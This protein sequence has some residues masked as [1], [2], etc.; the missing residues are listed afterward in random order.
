MSYSISIIIPAYNVEAYIEKCLNSIISSDLFERIFEIIM[1]NDGSTDNTL[2][3]INSFVDNN[4]IKII[5]KINGGVST[6]RN[7]G[8]KIA[9]GD[10]IWFINLDDY[11]NKNI[12]AIG[13]HKALKAYDDIIYFN[14]DLVFEDGLNSSTRH[15]NILTKEDWNET[16]TFIG[17]DFLYKYTKGS[18]FCV[19]LF[20]KKRIYQKK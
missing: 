7:E 20:N 4:K 19:D 15:I 1:V 8:L 3:K 10:Y 5:N 18:I 13:D 9:K 6:A 14:F 2:L 17:V 12:S 11:I 16:K